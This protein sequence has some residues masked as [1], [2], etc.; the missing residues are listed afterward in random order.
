MPC[1]QSSPFF[2][3]NEETHSPNNL[4]HCL[5]VG[6]DQQVHRLC[7]MDQMAH[8]AKTKCINSGHNQVPGQWTELPAKDGG[9]MPQ[10]GGEW[11]S[12]LPPRSGDS[13][14]APN[15]LVFGDMQ[16]STLKIILVHCLMSVLIRGSSRALPWIEGPT[17]SLSQDYKQGYHLT[18]K[19]YDMSKKLSI[20]LFSSSNLVSLGVRVSVSKPSVFKVKL[21]Y[22]YFVVRICF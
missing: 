9:P 7:H 15:S 22:L 5:Y 8:L 2:G 19:T 3:P 18:C 20:P 11:V 4:D 10:W 14:L 21:L 16:E 13:P 1:N 12:R 17:S 6:F